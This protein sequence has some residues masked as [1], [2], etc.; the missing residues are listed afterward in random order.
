[1]QQNSKKTSREIARELY[2]S[3]RTVENHRA[4]I[5][6]KLEL[7]GARSLLNFALEHKSELS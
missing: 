3:I 1:L 2:I 7:R 4:N 5:C 6:D